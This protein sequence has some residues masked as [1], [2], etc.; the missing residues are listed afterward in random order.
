M[1]NRKSTFDRE[2]ALLVTASE[3]T[4][5]WFFCPQ[6]PMMSMNEEYAEIDGKSLRYVLSL[7]LPMDMSHEC[8]S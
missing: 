4:S 1:Q 5:R 8:G 2:K 7:H 6:D 3:A